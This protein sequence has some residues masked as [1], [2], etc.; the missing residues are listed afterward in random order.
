[1]L[2]FLWITWLGVRYRIKATTYEVPMES[3]FVVEQPVAAIGGDA[4]RPDAIY[5]SDDRRLRDDDDDD[6][7]LPDG[8]R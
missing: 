5:R 8:G 2:P 6:G 4:V 3:L 1:V 7:D